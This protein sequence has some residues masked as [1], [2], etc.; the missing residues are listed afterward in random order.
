MNLE[1][2]CVAG[3]VFLLSC[4]LTKQLAQAKFTPH[5]LDHPNERSL[6]AAPK[7]RT[8][9]IAILISLAS[10]IIIQC[11]SGYARGAL[12][13]VYTATII[14]AL[15]LSLF[16][17]IV[18]FVDD[19]AELP[20]GFRLAVHLAIAAAVALGAGVT[21]DVTGLPYLGALKLEQ[22]SVP[23]TILWLVWMINLYNF[24]DGMD[25]FAGGMGVCGFG[26]L[27]Y[28]GYA[29]GHDQFASLALLVATATVGFLLYNV[30][31]AR[32][33]MG[34]VG[35]TTLGF[36][37]SALSLV[38]VSEGAFDFPVPVLIFSP[39]IVDATVTVLRRLARGEKIWQP[40][41]RHYYQRLVLSGWS[42]RKTVLC[43]YVLMIASGI[44]AVIY[45][46]MNSNNARGMLLL[47]WAAIYAMLFLGV[48]L[49]ERKERFSKQANAQ[50]ATGIE[51]IEPRG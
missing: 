29:A 6:H 11:F 47:M 12:G 38:G 9:G 30:P 33:F 3:L 27:A 4:W 20:S 7:P 26:F 17:A 21:F 22:L 35:S 19:W 42:H 24:M 25:G 51:P 28:F 18:S 36:L 32:I 39:F 31:P 5:L 14:W 43:E 46:K 48:H 8:G 50:L 49:V 16:L 41:R 10:G 44:S 1:S 23:L 34:D 13:G 2:L 45:N 15:A 40:H 37:A